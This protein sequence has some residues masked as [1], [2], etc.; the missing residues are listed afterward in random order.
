MEEATGREK[1]CEGAI[2]KRTQEEIATKS[3]IAESKD[4]KER[5]TKKY[6]LGEKQKK[7]R[8]YLQWRTRNQYWKNYYYPQLSK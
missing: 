4:T 2:R 3:K 5:E 7:N 1:I 6:D 8:K